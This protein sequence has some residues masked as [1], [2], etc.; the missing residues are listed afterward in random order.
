MVALEAVEHFALSSLRFER[1]LE[2]GSPAARKLLLRI[3]R[4]L[5]AGADVPRVVVPSKAPWRRPK[6]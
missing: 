6:T 5:A 2:E 3:A 1:L 4:T